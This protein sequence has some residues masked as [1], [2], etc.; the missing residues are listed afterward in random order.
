MKRKGCRGKKIPSVGMKNRENAEISVEKEL[1]QS[2]SSAFFIVMHLK[3][4]F[5]GRFSV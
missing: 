1:F 2:E 3:E 5:G 4:A